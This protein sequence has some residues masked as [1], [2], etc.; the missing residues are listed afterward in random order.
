M[1]QVVNRTTQLEL[2]DLHCELFE[3]DSILLEVAT[4]AVGI[5]TLLVQGMG[6]TDFGV[7]NVLT[8][9]TKIEHL[10]LPCGD[11]ISDASLHVIAKSCA[12][13]KSLR[14]HFVTRANRNLV[15]E[16]ALRLLLAAAGELEELSLHNCLLMT[17]H[18]FP[19]EGLYAGVTR[20]CLSDSLQMDD[21]AIE[22]A[23]Q[24]CPNV[25]YLDLSGLNNL[26]SAALAHVATWCLVLEE[27][28]LINCACFEDDSV[29][30]LVQVLHLVFVKLSRYPWPSLHSQDV[31]IFRG[32]A[33]K[34][35]QNVGNAY[36]I[37]AL[38]KKRLYG[39][40]YNN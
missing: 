9:C 24:L 20:L 39:Q 38:E 34:I 31:Q 10:V 4:H 22:R 26:G 5:R 14:L 29:M 12:S 23:V 13:L 7:Q 36:R 1:I 3:L 33:V 18:T 2:L 35:L 25:R 21:M 17:L 6:I 28:V 19:E 37:Q 30:Q 32:N 11:G 16:H 40:L 15:S 8:A 27:L